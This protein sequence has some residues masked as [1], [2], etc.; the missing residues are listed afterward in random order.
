MNTDGRS[1]KQ[2]EVSLASLSTCQIINDDDP[3]SPGTL[4]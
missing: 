4:L 3:E 2:I 1:V